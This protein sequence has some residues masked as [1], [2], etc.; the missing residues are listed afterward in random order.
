MTFNKKKI[1]KIICN[2]KIYNKI[3]E[4]RIQNNSN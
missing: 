2:F 3:I 1:V 4:K